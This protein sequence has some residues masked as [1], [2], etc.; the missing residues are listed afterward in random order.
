MAISMVADKYMRNKDV[1]PENIAKL[2]RFLSYRGYEFDKI[3]AYI[4]RLKRG[5]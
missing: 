5:E 2:I 3:N 1:T 4:G